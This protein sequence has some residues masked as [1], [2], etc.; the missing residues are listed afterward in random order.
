MT[1]N[2]CFSFGFWRIFGIISICFSCAFFLLFCWYFRDFLNS[3][4]SQCRFWDYFDFL[5]FCLFLFPFFGITSPF[6]P[7]SFFRII[8][9]LFLLDFYII[10]KIIKFKFV[11]FFMIFYS[12]ALLL[13]PREFAS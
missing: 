5:L 1:G 8:S 10:P 9:K 13:P 3:F 4:N 6:L 2:F 7:I 12:T 11:N